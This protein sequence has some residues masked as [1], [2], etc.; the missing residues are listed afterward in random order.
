MNYLSAVVAREA[1]NEPPLCGSLDR[2][3]PPGSVYLV[4][5]L[6][7][8]NHRGYLCQIPDAS[9]G[10]PTQPRSPDRQHTW[11]HLAKVS[12]TTAGEDR[13]WRPVTCRD[14][15]VTHTFLACDL[16]TFCWA[17]RDVVFSHRPDSWA[18]PTF[19]SCPVRPAM[20]SLPPSFQCGSVEQYVPYT[21]V[22]DHRR[23][24]ADG[25]DEILCTFLPCRG[26]AQFQCQNKQVCLGN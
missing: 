26:L 1:R 23:D 24:C 21:L 13:R 22:C 7:A 5:C 6:A 9:R 8:V 25:S 11:P 3:S 4:D 15:H 14:G 16:S 2:N 20:P 12:V 10:Q 18:L 17:D 19:Q